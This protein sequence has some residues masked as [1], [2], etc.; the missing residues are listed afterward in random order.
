MR[1]SCYVCGH[2]EDEHPEYGKCEAE[3]CDCIAFEL[4][5]DDEDEDE[6]GQHGTQP[7]API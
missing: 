1:T 3:G 2:S 6:E 4:D 5:E 7:V